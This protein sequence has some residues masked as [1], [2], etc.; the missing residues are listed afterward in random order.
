M[1]VGEGPDYLLDVRD[2]VLVA[3]SW[4]S[5]DVHRARLGSVRDVGCSP[6]LA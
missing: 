4:A 3:E 6:R 1:I 5:E 2:G